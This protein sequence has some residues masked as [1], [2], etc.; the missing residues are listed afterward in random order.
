MG[1][2]EALL[3]GA[4]RC[5]REK[6]FARTTARDVA[7]A[8]KVSLAAIGYHYGTVQALMTAALI[9]ATRQWGDLVERE[10]AAERAIAPTDVPPIERFER[11]WRR[12]I[13]LFA[14][15]RGLWAAHLEAAAA[16]ERSPELAEFFSGSQEEGRVGLA[17]IFHGNA[18]ARSTALEVGAMYQALLF[19]VMSQMLVDPTR[20]PTARQLAHAMQAIIADYGATP[21]AVDA[22]PTSKSRKPRARR[23]RRG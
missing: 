3:E 10:L 5:L 13:A 1:N 9:E 18:F 20:A 14:P 19:G 17:Q 21:P 12:I 16:S 23:T 7:Q 6:G 15:H 11:I 2:R 8:A 4:M 22:K